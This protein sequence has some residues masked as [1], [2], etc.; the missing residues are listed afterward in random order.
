[1]FSK[2]ITNSS[3]FLMMSQ[4]AQ[5]LY[6]HIGMNADDDG[7]CEI[8]TVMRMT[9]SKPDDLKVLHAKGFIFAID[10]KV[11]IVKDWHKN[12]LIRK[13][14]YIPSHYFENDNMKSIY[15]TI[16]KEKIRNNEAYQELLNGKPMVNQRLPQVRL[17]KVSKEE[18]KSSSLKKGKPHYDGKEMRL[19]KGKWFVIPDDG[20][21]PWLEFAGKLS[22]IEY[23]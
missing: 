6:F 10:D 21:H 23:K 11:C 19:V 15:L 9:D 22:D 17:G 13:D 7:F 8:F 2:V 5:G 12:N 3:D 18:S 20:S 1:M 16:M 14:R 4:S